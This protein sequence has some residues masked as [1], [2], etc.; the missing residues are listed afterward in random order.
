M[1]EQ[2]YSSST[3]AIMRN[4][5]RNTELD[6][7]LER[8]LAHAGYG[9]AEI[10]KTPLGTRITVYVTRPGLIIGRKGFG[11]RELTSKLEKEFGL[12]NPQVSVLEIEV[13]ELN[14]RIIANRVA[15]MITKGTAFRRAAV[16]AL[17]TIM[18]AG[19]M[20]AEVVISGKLRSE[21]A[22]FEKYTAGILPKSGDPA[23]KAVREAVTHVLLKMG[24]YGI[25]IKIAYRDALPAEFEL[26]DHD[27]VDE[28]KE[29]VESPVDMQGE[30]GRVEVEEEH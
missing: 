26:R 1:P 30:K 13:P 3:K 15:Q 19:A 6:E 14:P 2:T 27:L 23:E 25:K 22:S 21:R 16:W 5:F 8:E 10:Q 24:L 18:G 11:I 20:G 17:N 4:F 12:E 7:F 9:G 29:G 28:S